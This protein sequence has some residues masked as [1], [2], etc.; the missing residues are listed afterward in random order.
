MTLRSGDQFNTT[1][2]GHSDRFRGIEGTREVLPM[3]PG[4]IAEAGLEAGPS[5]ASS[6]T[7][8]TSITARWAG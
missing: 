7:S 6:P 3:S 2:H 5:C 1:I 8:T 4:D